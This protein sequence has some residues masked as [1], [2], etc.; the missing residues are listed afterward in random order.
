VLRIDAAGTVGEVPIRW[1][2]YHISDSSGRRAAHV[3]TFEAERLVQFGTT[4]EEIVSGFR[5][6]NQPVADPSSADSSAARKPGR[7]RSAS[8]S[9]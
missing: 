4:D 7:G 1:I 8:Q 6:R 2:Y 5:F 3:Y 9:R